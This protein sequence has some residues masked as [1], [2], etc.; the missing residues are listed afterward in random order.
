MKLL[1]EDEIPWVTAAGLYS[2]HNVRMVLKLLNHRLELAETL[3]TT[4]R[5]AVCIC[6]SALARTWR[7]SSIVSTVAF[8]EHRWSL[9]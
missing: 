4:R 5:V 7:Y 9:D 3:L 8:G 6:F 1:L 2:A